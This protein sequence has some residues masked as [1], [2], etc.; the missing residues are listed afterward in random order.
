MRK[1]AIPTRG[2]VDEARVFAADNAGASA[3]P[4]QSA[5]MWAAGRACAIRAGARR[6]TMGS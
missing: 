1:V 3:N 2:N 4:G 5:C 6:K